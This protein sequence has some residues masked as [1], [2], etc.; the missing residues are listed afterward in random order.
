MF[1]YDNALKLLTRY[2]Q[3]ITDDAPDYQLLVLVSQLLSGC[4]QMLHEIEKQNPT[5]DL[6]YLHVF[7][8]DRSS[9]QAS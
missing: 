1:L 2:G 9:Q 7:L 8:Q 4:G 6:D 5:T 3:K